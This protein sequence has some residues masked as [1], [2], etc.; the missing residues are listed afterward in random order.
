V[1]QPPT[2]LTSRVQLT[3]S[4]AISDDATGLDFEAIDE[5]DDPED[6]G[7]E[8]DAEADFGADV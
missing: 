6:T 2:S 7:T 4:T 5:L 8:P 1:S 3:D